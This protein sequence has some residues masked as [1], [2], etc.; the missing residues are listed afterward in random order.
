[1]QDVAHYKTGC[2]IKSYSISIILEGCRI[3]QGVNKAGKSLSQK[4][5]PRINGVPD[6]KDE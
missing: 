4:V 5:C 2:K 1:M 3:E 6:S